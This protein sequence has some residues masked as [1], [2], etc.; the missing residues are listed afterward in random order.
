[1]ILVDAVSMN[2]KV[3]LSSRA[4]RSYREKKK[5]VEIN[6]RRSEKRK[7]IN[8]QHFLFF[9]SLDL[10]HRLPY[11][12]SRKFLHH[13]RHHYHY[14]LSPIIYQPSEH[15]TSTPTSRLLATPSSTSIIHKPPSLMDSTDG[16]GP[17][18]NRTR[19]TNP[20]VSRVWFCGCCGWGCFGHG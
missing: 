20:G 7:M 11:H 4:S 2:I 5:L 9:F 10:F 13:D 18:M 3:S 6:V 17:E 14:H 8:R 16:H 19:L 1:M 12:L 15:R